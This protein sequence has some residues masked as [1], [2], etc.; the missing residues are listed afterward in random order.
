MESKRVGIYARVSTKD[1]TTENQLLDLRRYCEARGWQIT[2]ECVDHGLSG[3]KDERPQLKAVLG[4]A[5]KRK[6]DILL[7][8]RF[9]RFARSLSNLVN[10]LEELKCLGVDFASYQEN[11]DTSTAQGKMLFG[12]FVS[13]AE[14]ERALIV[15][16]IHAG[17]RRARAQGRRP[18][19]ARVSV[20]TA[21]LYQMRQAG[22]SLRDIGRAFSISR[23][24]V[25]RLLSQIPENAP[26]G[27][28]A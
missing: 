13:I 4:L 12:I 28:I 6:I 24:T 22:Q 20:D 17:L 2:A 19:P 15:E 10:S 3:T 26:V 16:R 8:W 9:D 18:G 7:V 1:Q 14:F 5:R 11:I 27:A 21:K 23:M 25:K